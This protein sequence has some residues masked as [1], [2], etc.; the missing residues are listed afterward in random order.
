M[1][2][3]KNNRKYS[4]PAYYMTGEIAQFLDVAPRT[5]SKWFDEGKLLGFRLPGSTDRRITREGVLHFCSEYGIPVPRELCEQVVYCGVP[6][7]LREQVDNEAVVLNGVQRSVCVTESL[8]EAGLVLDVTAGWSSLV[9]GSGC[10]GRSDRLSA[11]RGLR[12]RLPHC[13]IIVF[14]GDDE[15]NA[16]DEGVEEWKEAGVSRILLT[17]HTPK[18]LREA[19][20]G[21]ETELGYGR[22]VRERG[23]RTRGSGM[24]KKGGGR[25]REATKNGEG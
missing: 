15:G 11:V 24:F 3:G 25:E 12:K 16:D 10:G 18:A 14:L 19:L 2:R 5:V 23:R 8:F 6:E 7:R 17:P 22:V 20:S 4:R 21:I 9:L 13:W 1:S